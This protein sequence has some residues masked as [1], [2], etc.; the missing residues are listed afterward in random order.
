M[1]DVQA[2][3]EMNWVVSLV[4]KIRSLRS[5]YDIAPGEPVAIQLMTA[6]ESIQ[7]TCN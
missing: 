3:V 2:D 1:R 6:D 5:E 7:K 4:T